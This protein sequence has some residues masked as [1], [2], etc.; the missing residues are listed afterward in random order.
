MARRNRYCGI[1][2]LLLPFFLILVAYVQLS[3]IDRTAKRYP[4]A[5][6]HLYLKNLILPLLITLPNI[7]W[8]LLY[9]KYRSLLG[10]TVSH[11]IIGVWVLFIL[12]T[13]GE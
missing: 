4:T 8:C 1:P 3:S 2:L 10:V 9:Y 13:P 5:H 12:G 7:F 6:A 11:I